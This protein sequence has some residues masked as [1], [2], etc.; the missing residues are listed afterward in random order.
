MTSPR[1]PA[2]LRR[3]LEGQRVSS[4]AGAILPEPATKWEWSGAAVV[5]DSFLL[6]TVQS[7]VD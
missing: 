4:G 3:A 7:A 2:P 5:A 1:R 6:P